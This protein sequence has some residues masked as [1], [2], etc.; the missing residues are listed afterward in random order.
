MLRVEVVVL[1][2]YLRGSSSILRFGHIKHGK[3]CGGKV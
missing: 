3:Q 2:V 1:G